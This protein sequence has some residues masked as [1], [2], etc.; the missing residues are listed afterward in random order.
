MTNTNLNGRTPSR[1]VILAAEDRAIEFCLVPEWPC[2]VYV[3]NLTGAERDA[4]EGSLLVKDGKG[5]RTVTYT[6]LRAKLIART[7]CDAEGNR[8]FTDKDITLL[9]LKSAAPLQRIFEAQR[10]SGL[11]SDDVA[12]LTDELKN[13]QSAG[14]TSV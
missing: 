12:E 2:D 3:K 6:D 10:L 5:R 4:F 14:S 7:V 1:E 8:L 9:T 11:S 13:D